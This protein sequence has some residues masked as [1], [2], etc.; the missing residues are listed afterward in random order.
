L[1]M[2]FEPI[3]CPYC[4]AFLVIPERVAAGQRV[5]CPRCG[6]M[7]QYRPADGNA[8]ELASSPSAAGL[9]AEPTGIRRSNRRIAASILR[10]MSVM[11]GVA[12]VFA[13]KTVDFRRSRDPQTP[14]GYLPPD[15]NVVAGVLVS[16]A[17]K[18]PA[19]QDFLKSFRLGPIDLSISD[20]EHW[21]G[22]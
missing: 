5:P 8:R 16:E 7:V 1:I 13:L 3:S 14:L 20:L 15:T 4:N 12:L 10:I 22:L 21:T 6:E 9:P 2:P 19:G 18:E 17:L 11:G